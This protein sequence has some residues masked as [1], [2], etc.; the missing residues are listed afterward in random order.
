MKSA[1]ENNVDHG[2][3]LAR[4]EALFPGAS[5]PW[6]DL[7]TG[8]N[9][10]AYPLSTLPATVWTRLP[11]PEDTERLQALAAEHYGAPSSAN[12]VAAAGTQILLP[13]IYALRPA[14]TVAVLGPTYE[15]HGRA[16]RIAG[17]AVQMVGTVEALADADVAVIVNPNNPD[18]RVVSQT[19][20]LALAAK[21]SLLVVDEAFMDVGPSTQ[22]LTSDVSAENIVVLRSFGKFFGLAGVRLG[23]ALA[24]KNIAAGLRARLG[25]WA[26]SGPALAYGLAA[27][28]DKHWQ[29][30]TRARLAMEA[31]RLHKLLQTTG[32]AVSVG[33]NLY[34]HLRLEGAVGLFRHLGECGVYVRAFDGRPDELRFGLPADEAGWQRLAEA[35]AAWANTT[36][37]KMA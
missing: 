5:K 7:S 28:A 12:V 8:I 23:F 22:S 34:R 15:E 26:V 35:L 32:G 14:G 10:H 16:A 4:A 20:L 6:V 31:D 3:S 11:E 25:P 17:H 27:I 29:E 13:M 30:T 1:G 24:N 37:R 2:G 9:P 19:D 36:R 33:A 18:G 21:V